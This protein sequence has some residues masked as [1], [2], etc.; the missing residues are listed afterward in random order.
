MFSQVA[1]ASA[2]AFTRLAIRLGTSS[3]FSS[4]RFVPSPT[5]FLATLRAEYDRPD[6]HAT[7]LQ[8]LDHA[9]SYN[10]VPPNVLR[11]FDSN[12]HFL[13]SCFRGWPAWRR[14]DQFLFEFGEKLADHIHHS[15][16]SR[17]ARSSTRARHQWRS[18]QIIVGRLADA[19]PFVEEP[20][21]AHC[22]IQ[23]GEPF[24]GLTSMIADSEGPLPP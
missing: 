1:T 5:G 8:R 17:R 4:R 18:L 9:A 15:A 11:A 20:T 24:A 16:A 22:L 13:T 21:T 3:G 23:L 6:A 19:F 10:R 14:V 7:L 12:P 2:A